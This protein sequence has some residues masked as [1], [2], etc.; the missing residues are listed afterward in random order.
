V[1]LVLDVI[2]AATFENKSRDCLVTTQVAAKVMYSN[3]SSDDE[4]LLGSQALPQ[5]LPVRENQVYPVLTE[6]IS[7]IKH[8]HLNKK[9]RNYPSRFVKCSRMEIETVLE[10]T[11]SFGQVILQCYT[12]HFKA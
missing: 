11:R 1:T 12:G 2:P 4:A 8:Q 10:Q 7:D 6:I 9:L 3:S 5:E